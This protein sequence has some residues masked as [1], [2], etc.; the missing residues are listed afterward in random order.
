MKQT[1]ELLL[2]GNLNG[3]I[4][5]NQKYLAI[6]N[7][8]KYQAGKATC[9]TNL[10]LINSYTGNYKNSLLF[11]QNAESILKDSDDMIHKAHLYDQYGM[12]NLLLLMNDTGHQ[13]FNKALYCLKKSEDS[14]MK[15]YL[16]Q[17]V[18]IDK[19]KVVQPDSSLIYL[20]KARNIKK[21]ITTE[22]MIAF[23]HFERNKLDSTRIYLNNAFR[24]ADREKFLNGNQ[25]Y[26]YFIAGRYY[27][28]MHQYKK[29]EEA[30]Q[31]ALKIAMATK[32]IFGVNIHWIYLDLADLY[33]E[34]GDQK[35]EHEYR[36]LYYHQIAKFE[37][38][39]A[40]TANLS[41]KAFIAAIK[42]E[43]KEEKNRI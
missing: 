11:L 27:L 3:G 6:A 21:D 28:K 18:Y 33:K 23:R 17:L 8:E 12:L 24:I 39:Q 7:E 16:L 43:G 35:K 13:Y 42:N 15:Q 26:L 4:N 5:L 32:D 19:S 31:K 22:G 30:Y 34:T 20:H 36:D 1:E 38:D 9:Y 29:S 25:N 41:T 10:A 2:S 37:K 14:E 40:E